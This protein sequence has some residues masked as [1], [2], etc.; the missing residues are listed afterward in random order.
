MVEIKALRDQG[1]QIGEMLSIF[2]AN[3]K[4]KAGDYKIRL[5]ANSVANKSMDRLKRALELCAEADLA[6]KS[7]TGSASPYLPIERLIC[8]L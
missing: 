2:N 7:T 4:K 6:L 8:G 5:Y 1:I 3:K